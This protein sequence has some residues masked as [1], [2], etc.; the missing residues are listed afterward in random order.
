MHAAPLFSL[1]TALAI[2][3]LLCL[4]LLI[5]PIQELGIS[6]HLLIS[7]LIS[8][9][10]VLQFSAYRSFVPLGRVIPRYFILF[11]AM[12]NE[13]VSLISLSEFSSLVYARDFCALIL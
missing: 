11:V 9:I 12:V 13:S 4:H 10:S 1:K 5:L 2:R 3:G 7:S 6:L 8:F